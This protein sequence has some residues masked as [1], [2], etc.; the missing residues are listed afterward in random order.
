MPTQVNHRGFECKALLDGVDLNVTKWDGTSTTT[1]L[2]R[3]NT[4]HYDPVE[5]RCYKSVIGG[6]SSFE[7]SITFEYDSNNKPWPNLRD[8]E[9]VEI[10]QLKCDNTGSM[11]S[12][13]LF[14][15]TLKVAPDSIDGLVTG[16]LTFSSDGKITYT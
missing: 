7:G 4:S 3:T 11:I 2:T 9:F 13:R 14:I 1:E 5:D 10:A 16:E 6:V 15:K 8:G 12:G